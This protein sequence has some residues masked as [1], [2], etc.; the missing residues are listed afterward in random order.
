MADPYESDFMA[1]EGPP[2]MTVG[3]KSAIL[4]LM[5][6]SAMSMKR[7]VCSLLLLG[8]LVLGLLACN[9]PPASTST[10]VTK[11]NSIALTAG[12]G[13]GETARYRVRLM[14]GAA[15]PVGRSEDGRVRLG[16]GEAQHGQHGRT[17]AGTP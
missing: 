12:G 10:A 17:Q 2:A 6:R 5:R 3:K 4:P 14:V 9:T 13:Q 11:Q 8:L 1:G 7:N 15:M 16:P